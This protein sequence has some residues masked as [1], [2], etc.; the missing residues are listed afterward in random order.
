[1]VKNVGLLFA[2]TS[3]ILLYRVAAATL[4]PTAWGS[5]DTAETTDLHM[6]TYVLGRNGSGASTFNRLTDNADSLT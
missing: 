5:N 2:L 4:S 1:M 3:Q 6:Y